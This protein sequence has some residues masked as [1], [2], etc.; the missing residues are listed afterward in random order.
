[1]RA[2]VTLRDQPR[3]YPPLL[4]GCQCGAEPCA[5][6]AVL[7]QHGAVMGCAQ[8]SLG[9]CGES[10]VRLTHLLVDPSWVRGIDHC[11]QGRRKF[12]P[13]TRYRRRSRPDHLVVARQP[14]PR[15]GLILLQS[16]DP[17]A[18]IL[19]RSVACIFCGPQS[20]VAEDPFHQQL[21]HRHVWFSQRVVLHHLIQ[22]FFCFC[23]FCGGLVEVL[24]HEVYCRPLAVAGQV[25]PA[26]GPQCRRNVHNGGPFRRGERKVST[27]GSLGR[28]RWHLNAWRAPGDTHL[29][30]VPYVREVFCCLK[31][32][33]SVSAAS[34]ACTLRSFND[35]HSD[36][37]HP[38]MSHPR[39]RTGSGGLWFWKML[40][41]LLRETYT[42]RTPSCNRAT[43]GRPFIRPVSS[44][45]FPARRFC[46]SGTAR[47]A[48]PPSNF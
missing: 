40:S 13:A 5:H 32:R 42:R 18:K 7:V 39:T 2:M 6:D 1:M 36:F 31:V 15:L 25:P 46:L 35:C 47:L 45:C 11:A 17:G 16:L 12:C 23:H 24:P 44:S 30:S 41:I 27:W 37:R 4:F 26:E 21:R 19:L 28:R 8:P 48:R 20:C 3:I 10:T 22:L 34:I 29:A 14:L 9:Q 33:K 43:D 38:N